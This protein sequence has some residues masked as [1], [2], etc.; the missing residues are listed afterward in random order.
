VN[1][2][3][4]TAWLV[5]REESKRMSES[6]RRLRG[7]P[8]R[9]PQALALSLEFAAANKTAKTNNR[10]LGLIARELPDNLPIPGLGALAGQRSFQRGKLFFYLR[11]AGSELFCRSRHGVILAVLGR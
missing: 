8:Y 10:R 11:Q 2:F 9:G 6:T 4:G 5:I 7:D 3:A 1:H